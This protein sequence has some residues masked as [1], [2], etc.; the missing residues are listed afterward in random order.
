MN[1]LGKALFILLGTGAIA[2]ATLTETYPAAFIRSP[3]DIGGASHIIW[4]YDASRMARSVI[5]YYG[6]IN[7]TSSTQVLTNQAVTKQART[8]SIDAL[9]KNALV[10]DLVA[11]Q[12]TDADVDALIAETMKKEAEN[13]GLSTAIGIVYGLDTSGFMNLIVRPAAER[14]VVMKTNKWNDAG[15]AAWLAKEIAASSIVRFVK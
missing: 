4:T 5:T 11:T 15:L 13:P 10:G 2:T 9:I 12:G 7:A 1:H 8:E 3:K 14:E 6:T